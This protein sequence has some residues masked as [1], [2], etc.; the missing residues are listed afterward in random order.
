MRRR[1]AELNADEDSRLLDANMSEWLR[2]KAPDQP[3]NPVAA[4][5]EGTLEQVVAA[6]VDLG[7][8]RERLAAVR[9]ASSLADEVSAGIQPFSDGS[10]LVM[11]SDSII[12][13]AM[14]YG[15]YAGS[16]LSHIGSAGPVRGIWR[17]L[18]ATLNGGLGEDPAVLT[19]LLRYYNINQRVYGLSAKLGF[20]VNSAAE[21]ACMLIST[22]ALW[23]ILGH[24]LA[25]HAL[26]HNSPASGFSPSECLPVCS[27]DQQLEL[28]ADM[29]AYR[30]AVRSFQREISKTP[31]LAGTAIPAA[32]DVFAALGAAV[33][34]LVVHSD[35]QAL[36]VRR[37][38]SHPAAPGRA[39]LLLGRLD[40]KMR[41]FADLC[42]KNMLIACE[43]SS[44]FT[45]TSPA[46]D[47]A[48]FAAEPRID[49]P[50][51]AQY[52]QGIAQFDALQRL[53]GPDIVTVLERIG[54]D[55]SS[56][57]VGDGTRLAV[58]GSPGAALRAW[59]VPDDKVDTIG[60]HT[61]ALT[62]H[63]LVANV[64]TGFTVLPLPEKAV[65]PAAVAAATL[66][67]EYLH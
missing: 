16:A 41:Q 46:F 38:S 53:P 10:A 9:I 39:A 44:T 36:F 25:H 24:E 40:P 51:P 30:V 58:T 43:A 11:I 37:G 20:R 34:M 27:A 35:E 67:A 33:A 23:F 57:A 54:A 19:G 55:S 61:R 64:A 26:G 52:L 60:D 17:T 31:E 2:V 29:L 1:L 66:I 12:T 3:A 8:S 18:R 48:R 45:A 21:E 49:T 50:H 28:D 13:L 5:L 56:A 62:F 63:T 15:Q 7:V 14:L 65:R 22:L 59:G 6:M 42:L 4:L 47:W 32:A